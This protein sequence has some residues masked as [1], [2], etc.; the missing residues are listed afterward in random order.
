MAKTRDMGTKRKQLPEYFQKLEDEDN[1][2]PLKTQCRRMKAQE[3]NQDT[4][5]EEDQE[6]S[7]REDMDFIGEMAKLAVSDEVSLTNQN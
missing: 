6:E 1:Y 2:I 5:N 4:N 7:N 3:R